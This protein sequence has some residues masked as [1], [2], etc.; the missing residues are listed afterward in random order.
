MKITVH[1][2]EVDDLLEIIRAG[3]KE[4][5]YEESKQSEAHNVKEWDRLYRVRQL[6]YKLISRIKLQASL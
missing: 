6:A 5:G 4:I 3:A 2:S 1:K